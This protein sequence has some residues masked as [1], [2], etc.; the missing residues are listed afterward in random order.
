[1][2]IEEVHQKLHTRQSLL[3]YLYCF[4]F[5][6]YLNLIRLKKRD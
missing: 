6:I 3:S 2:K 5:E 4:L 1:M